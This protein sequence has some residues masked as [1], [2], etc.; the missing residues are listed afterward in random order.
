[1]IMTTMGSAYW[2][3]TLA[4]R[5]LCWLLALYAFAIFGYITATI[6]SFF[7]AGSEK[8]E[9]EP[10]AGEPALDLSA[11]QAELTAMRQQLS[12][13]VSRFEVEHL[14]DGVVREVLP[15]R[16]SIQAERTHPGQSPEKR[17]VR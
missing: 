17:R 5:I 12:V 11:L 2:P 15:A 14:P 13:L 4:G 3:V 9:T 7:L 16:C 8:E 10:S 1:M 6:A